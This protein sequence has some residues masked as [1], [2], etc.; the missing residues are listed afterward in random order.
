MA[1]FTKNDGKIAELTLASMLN[2]VEG[3]IVGLQVG[4]TRDST[5]HY[6]F[7][8]EIIAGKKHIVRYPISKIA[9]VRVVQPVF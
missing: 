6:L 7:S 2:D 1:I 9:S 3:C 5:T 4:P 8:E